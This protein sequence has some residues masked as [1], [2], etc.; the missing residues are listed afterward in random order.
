MKV[1]LT[2][3]LGLSSL[4]FSNGLISIPGKTKGPDKD[5][6]NIKSLTLSIEGTEREVTD[7]DTCKIKYRVNWETELAKLC[8]EVD[9]KLKSAKIVM[10]GMDHDT[11]PTEVKSIDGKCANIEKID[12]L[13]VGHWRFVFDFE[14]GDQGSI[15]LCI[16]D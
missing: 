1:L 6:K 9:S 5:D 11:P 10:P 4:G 7:S 3:L 16:E 12:F 13:M 15:D 2:I 8:T 14:D